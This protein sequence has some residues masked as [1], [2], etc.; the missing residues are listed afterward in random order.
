MQFTTYAHVPPLHTH[1]H[2]PCL[3]IFFRRDFDIGERE[4]FEAVLDPSRISTETADM[5]HEQFGDYL[6][7][8]EGELSRSLA[9][10]S[11]RFFAA[12]TEQQVL[13]HQVIIALDDIRN[14]RAQLA[15]AQREAAD[16]DLRFL[17]LLSSRDSAYVHT[18][19]L[20]CLHAY[21]LHA[22][23]MEGDG[24]WTFIMHGGPTC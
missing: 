7:L 13:H 17:Q 10:R 14:L 6:D 12:L 15:H 21:T 20:V 19:P 3:K 23:M 2:T 8:V 24:R 18:C 1:T 22:C 4:T 16:D 5:M 11:K 9:S